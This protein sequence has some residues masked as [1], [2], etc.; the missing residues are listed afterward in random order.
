MLALAREAGE[1]GGTAPVRLQRGERGRRR[2]VPRRPAAVPR[3]RRGRRGRARAVRR[4]ARARPRPTCSR[5]TARRAAA[6]QGLARRMTWLVV[7]GRPCSCSCSCTSSVTSPSRC[8]SACGRA[9]STSA[10]RRRSS[11]CSARASSTASARSRSAACVRIPGMNRPVGTRR[12][13]VHAAAVREDAALAAVRAARTPRA[14]RRGLRRPR[15]PLCR[16]C[17]SELERAQLSTSARRS[18]N[19][20]LRELDEGTGPDAYWRAG[21]LEAHR[22]HRRRARA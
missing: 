3:D 14:R 21:D 9:A 19:R 22:D 16:S 5:S 8:S 7:A 1:K 20:A 4:R 15:A 18:A 10:S 13:D 17:D 2:R 6:A 12:R 11:R